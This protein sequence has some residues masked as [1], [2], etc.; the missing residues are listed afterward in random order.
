MSVVL[1][2]KKYKRIVPN[3]KY[4]AL[5]I[6]L[7]LN[8]F[9]ISAQYNMVLLLKDKPLERFSLIAHK[10]SDVD[11]L[12]T[13]RLNIS[14]YAHIVVMDTVLPGIGTLVFD[15]KQ[16]LDVILNKE[17]FKIEGLSKNINILDTKYINSKENISL[18]NYL[19]GIKAPIDSSLYSSKLIS[20]INS[21]SADSIGISDTSLDWPSV[22][23]SGLWN[24]VINKWVG[25]HFNHKDDKLFIKD[26]IETVDEIRIDKVKL[27]F[28]NTL[29]QIFE[30]NQWLHI[31]YKLVEHFY[32]HP[33][34]ITPKGKILEKMRRIGILIGDRAPDFIFDNGTHLSDIL[35][36]KILI[37]F[38]DYT[39]DNCQK[40]LQELIMN[41]QKIKSKDATIVTVSIGQSK[42]THDVY[43]QLFPWENHKTDKSGEVATKFG[44]FFV[45]SFLL[46]EQGVLTKRTQDIEE[47]I[48]E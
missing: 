2:N 7:V 28:I 18:F 4:I 30:F 33:E 11:T 20:I 16:Q 14:G 45:P 9:T 47:L 8:N 42:I 39:C 34:K 13:G 19:S 36:N 1:N 5:L 38:F 12:Y 35:S 6:L 17:D 21:I 31:E 15:D 43:D 3:L 48:S 32:L 40:D 22:Y 41:Y 26:I 25:N 24:V 23:T 27:D 10:G 44:I 29:L 37:F 46:I